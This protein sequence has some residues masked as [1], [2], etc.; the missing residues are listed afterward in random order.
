MSADEVAEVLELEREVHVVH[1]DIRSDFENDGREIKHA[2]DADCD[3]AVHDGLGELDGHAEDGELDG[4]RGDEFFQIRVWKNRDDNASSAGGLG[5][6]IEGGNDLKAFF[7]ETVVAEERGAE[8]TRSDEDDWLKVFATE[9]L[10]DDGGEG[11]YR[12]TEATRAELTEVGEVLAKLRGLHSGCLCQSRG[13]DGV[14]PVI[15]QFLQAAV[16]DG[17]PIDRLFRDV[18]LSDFFREFHW[19]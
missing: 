1:G 5:I 7:F 3:E 9:C 2:L 11:L 14:H 4:V 19:K 13:T 16:V 15:V 8:I 12:V 18:D 6:R 10:A 17:K